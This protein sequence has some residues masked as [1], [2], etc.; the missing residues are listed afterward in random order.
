MIG[1]A[2]SCTKNDQVI[3]PDSGTA[4]TTLVSLKTTTAPTIDGVID[5][6]WANATKLSV[7]PT[8]PDPGNNLF[9]GYI[10]TTYSAT[11]RSMYDDQNIYFLVEVVD[12]NKNVKNAPWYF[13][14]TTKLWA[15][16]PNSRSFDASGVLVREGYGQDKFAMLWNIDNSTAKFAA[17]TCYA[18]CHVFT[19]YIDY[20]GVT[21][22]AK[23][24]A[25]SGNHYTNGVNEKIDMWWAHPDRGLAFGNM[26]DN[27]QDWAGGPGVVN[28]VGGSGNGRHFDDLVVS[29]ASAT[30]PYAP[31]YTAD[32]TQGSFTNKQT[33]KLDGTGSSVSVPMWVIP[34]STGDNIKVT[35]TIAGGTAVRIT[36]VSSTG[37]LTYTG[38]SIDPTVGTDYQR[39]G[40]PVTGG[41]GPKCISSTIVSPILRGRADISCTSVYTGTGW[42]YE[43]KRKLKTGDILKQD[44]DFTSLQDQPFG[45]AVWNNANYQHGIQPNLLLTFGK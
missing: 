34:N 15:Q 9:S 3:I 38:G 33:L 26:D 17:Q 37:V 11:L 45:V 10:G 29:G 28:L 4:S 21:P 2:V 24:N 8:V 35:D 32:A 14:P 36:G 18:S 16:E 13:N 1:Y 27:Y 43:F 22:V 23:S 44:I 40:D 25:A 39:I 42:I 31:T 19:P 7:T 6:I 30:W 12:A 5:P 41:L 20:S